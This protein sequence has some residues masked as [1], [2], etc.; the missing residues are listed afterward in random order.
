MSAVTVNPPS[1]SRVAW[2][3]RR[4]SFVRAWQSFAVRRSGLV[5]LVLLIV[6]ALLALLAPVL[7]NADGLDVTKV[8]G[9]QLAP[10]SSQYLLGTDENGRSI[11]LLVWWGARI[12]LLVGLTAALLTV[13]IGTVVGLV[14]A[15]FGGWLSAVLMRVTD[16][17]LVMPSL[18]LAIAL[19]AVLAHGEVTIVIA[20]GLTSWPT[21]AR[22]VRAQTLTIE[23]RPY[24]ERAR[25][26]GGGHWH[27]LGRHVLPAVMPLVLANTTL[28]VAGAIVGESTLA[29]LGLGDPTQVSWGLMLNQAQS[30]GAVSAGAWWYLLPPGL[31]IVV[32]VLAF[33]LCGRA[34]EQVLMPAMRT[35]SG[36]K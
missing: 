19:S 30:T 13:V 7:S 21:T 15:H 27:V 28:T 31:G 22:I 6:I 20:L 5:G 32:V 4:Q 2:T 3:R 14:S 26:L 35:G 11:L 25:A 29:F 24:I 36:K 23:T 8:N 34:L 33:T 16:F 18:V 10:P 17:F 9:P 1:A 12:S